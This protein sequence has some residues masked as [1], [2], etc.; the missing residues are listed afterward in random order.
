MKESTIQSLILLALSESGCTVWRNE[1]AGAWVG[2][3]IHQSHGTVTIADARMI[4]AGLCVGGADIIGIHPGSG[5]MI[6][7]EVKSATGRATPE[8]VRFIETVRACG[9][10]SGVARSVEDALQLIR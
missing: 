9:G 2:K 6:A 3:V 8:Q 1:T 5:R 4:Q 7:I 10:I